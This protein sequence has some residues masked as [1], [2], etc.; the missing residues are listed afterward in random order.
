MQQ[1]QLVL[2]HSLLLFPANNILKVGHKRKKIMKQRDIMKVFILYPG[3]QYMWFWAYKHTDTPCLSQTNWAI[4]FPQS[5]SSNDYFLCVFLARLWRRAVQQCRW[6]KGLIPTRHNP[7]RL[8]YRQSGA[9]DMPWR[10][11]A[12]DDLQKGQVTAKRRSLSAAILQGN[13]LT[14]VWRR[15]RSAHSVFTT[16]VHQ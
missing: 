13:T 14:F 15:H 6:S 5:S 8:K 10:L 3:L 12:Q 4:T 16:I 7:T 2:F 1:S 11:Q 9:A